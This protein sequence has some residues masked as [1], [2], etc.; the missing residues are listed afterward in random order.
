MAKSKKRIFIS[1]FLTKYME[2]KIIGQGGNSTVYEVIDEDNNKYALKLLNKKISTEN[3]KRFK[4]EINFCEKSDNSNLIKIIDNGTYEENGELLMFYVMPIY[5]YSLREL[6]KQGIDDSKKLDYFNQILEG[7]KF[8]HNRN[9][10]HRDIKP[11][12]I[13]YDEKFDKLVVSDLGIS[14]FNTDDLYTIIETKESSR[15][16][17]FQ[18]AAPEQREKNEIIDH[19][20]DIYSLGLILNEFFTGHLPHGT[21]YKK[22]GSINKEYE[23][24]DSIIDEMLRQDKNERPNKIEDIQHMINVKLKLNK[25][26][27]KI[28]ELK[29]IKIEE[30]E[31]KDILILDPPR[32]ID[33]IYDEEASRLKFTLSTPVNQKWVDC[34]KMSNRSSLLGYG[35]EVFR[36]E[37]EF[38]SVQLPIHSIDYSQKIIDYFKEW[39]NL[40]NAYYPNII[41]KERKKA[42]EEKEQEIKTE[43]LKREKIA[44]VMNNI[45]I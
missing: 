5:S 39:I 27:K 29:Q 23:F 21:N 10:F 37:R 13:L 7:V 6:M 24:L 9:N 16:A 3:L 19:R 22:I 8:L 4:N 44:S 41:K 31:E 18:Y 12:N 40:A 26:N 30:S 42:Q 1:A 33:V 11:E 36:F 28:E 20:A 35:V 15:L 14:H 34:I 43:I 32:L 17:N 25:E 2:V 38:A 45:K